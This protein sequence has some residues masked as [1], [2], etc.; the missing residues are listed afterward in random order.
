MTPRSHTPASSPDEDIWDAPAAD[1]LLRPTLD[2]RHDA[3]G[4]GKAFDPQSLWIASFFGGAFTAALMFAIN[5]RRLG[6]PRQAWIV[7][8]SFFAA[9]I[10]ATV[11]VVLFALDQGALTD[12]GL[13][14]DAS[15]NLR[16]VSR[17][18]G[19][20]LGGIGFYLQ[21]ARF[22]LFLHEGNDAAKA[23][24]PCIAAIAA[25]AIISV[26]L[27][28]PLAVVIAAIA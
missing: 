9:G 2:Q 7:G 11:V 16:G 20:V 23:L 12:E 8:G 19:I 26:A 4:F 13:G 5:A 1:D 17:V 21:R 24:L 6:R 25:S 22:R 10:V 14:D 18:L 27:V 3:R 28:F 15:R